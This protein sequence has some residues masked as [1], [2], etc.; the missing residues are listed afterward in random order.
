MTDLRAARVRRWLLDD[1][2]PLWRGPGVDEEAFGVWEALDHAGRPLQDL[3]KRLRVQ[4]R[5]S[6]A[7]STMA[8]V[9]GTDD[10]CLAAQ[11][12]KDTLE[13]GVEKG[14]GNLASLFDRHGGI[15]AAPHELY[16]VA[17]MLLADAGLRLAGAPPDHSSDTLLS[18]LKAKR[19]WRENLI[20]P[21][22]PRRQNPH[23]HLF[24]ASLAQHRAGVEG[25]L[26]I[27]EE[28]LD[29]FRDIFLQP[30][31]HVLE[32]F[33]D[34]WRPVASGQR[35][36]PGHIA[37]WI[38]LIDLYERETGR[39]SGI[40]LD[41]MFA[42]VLAS[43]D[44]TGFLSDASVPIVSTRRLWPQTEFLKA[45]IVMAAR[46]AAPQELADEIMDATFAAYFAAPERGGWYDQFD[47][48]GRLVSSTM[49]A[50]SLYHVLT[51]CLA[52]MNAVSGEAF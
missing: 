43:R 37:E 29:L 23:M 13:Y 22:Q 34:N 6:F 14:S 50:S 10:L 11:L 19:G 16:D 8:R 9:F 31:G 21:D 45:A 33:D 3:P 36:E 20:S 28:C 44:Q 1:V 27:A 26:D 51:A 40:D 32:L 24:E 46:R 12:F 17:F 7:F 35:I 41:R 38:Y 47:G 39:S 52:Y 30:D 4:A 42:R 15:L 25:Y 48:E 2:L 49:P 5:Q 18:R